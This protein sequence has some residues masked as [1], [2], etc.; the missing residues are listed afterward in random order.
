MVIAV[1]VFM[2]REGFNAS[3]ALIDGVMVLN[4]I[5]RSDWLMAEIADHIAIP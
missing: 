4:L 3:P 1:T 2:S 5:L